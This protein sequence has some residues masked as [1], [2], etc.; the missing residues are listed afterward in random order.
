[1]AQTAHISFFPSDES[2]QSYLFRTLK[3]NGFSDYS[4]ILVPGAGWGTRPSLPYE[5]REILSEDI[6]YLL[7]RFEISTF[8]QES[9]SSFSNHFDYIQLFYKTFFPQKKVRSAG[10]GIPV[11]Y[12][13]Q[14]MIEQMYNYGFSYF[15]LCWQY[16]RHCLIHSSYLVVIRAEY[17]TDLV[18][19]INHV[20][21]CEFNGEITADDK[22]S[23][24]IKRKVISERE[25]KF[26]PCAKKYLLNWA[27]KNFEYYPTGYA[28]TFDYGAMTNAE[29]KAFNL[30]KYKRLIEIN[31]DEY[32][33]F[34]IDAE[35]TRVLNFIDETMIIDLV[36]FSLV[37]GQSEQKSLLK[38]KTAN[39]TACMKHSFDDYLD[40]SK[41]NLIYSQYDFFSRYINYCD[42]DF[43]EQ[44]RKINFRQDELNIRK[45]EI[46]VERDI[47]LSR[48]YKR[49]GGKKGYDAH[50]T[51]A[52]EQL[53]S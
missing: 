12:C 22:V 35:Y 39:C 4:S 42:S 52:I 34:L 18:S 13:P 30:I 16:Q 20:L 7:K 49:Y 38:C 46:K 31:W 1:M 2:L 45:G 53:F 26:A 28:S 47:E 29:R 5:A 36:S 3:V 44:E 40:C 9:E 43:F 50:V 51:Q 33:Q 48:E 15:K 11:Y 25:L 8:L 10:K 23:F 21:R 27:V 37:V 17:L 41:A 24:S 6:P 32:Y 14:C 19:S